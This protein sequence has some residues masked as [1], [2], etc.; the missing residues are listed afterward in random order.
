MIT[1]EHISI[2]SANMHT[3]YRWVWD[4]ATARL[5]QTGLEADDEQKIGF[6]KSDNTTW[7]LVDWDAVESAD[8][9]TRLDAFADEHSSLAKEKVHRVFR[10]EFA[11]QAARDAI[12]TGDVTASDIGKVAI[13][14][15]P[16]R[17]LWMLTNNNPVAWKKVDGEPWRW[18]VD[19]EDALNALTPVVDDEYRLALVKDTNTLYVRRA[20]SWVKINNVEVEVE[21]TFDLR[22][23]NVDEPASNFVT[24]QVT[25]NIK[26]GDVT[27]FFPEKRF[28]SEGSEPSTFETADVAEEYSRIPEEYRPIEEIRTSVVLRQEEMGVWTQVGIVRLF[29]DGKVDFLWSIVDNNSLTST[30]MFEG[31]AYWTFFAFS[32]TYKGAV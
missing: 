32:V 2:G 20:S 12:G 29:P 1:Q 21:D 25:K 7:V 14:E 16:V 11:D 18:V 19:D 17:S 24:V 6:Q 5:A 3:P 8:K 23:K 22:F 30:T 4:N 26:T 27:L 13:Q 10:W 9:W 28:L 15:A 31:S